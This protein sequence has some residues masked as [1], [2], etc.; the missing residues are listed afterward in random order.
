[1]A[2]SRVPALDPDAMSEHQRLVHDAILAGPR[3]VVRGPLQGWLQRPGLAEHAQTLGAY[4]RFGTS[5]PPRLT[6][7]AILVTAVF[8]QAGYEWRGHAPFALAA[9]LSPDI[10]E[11]L[12]IGTTPEFEHGDEQIVHQFAT[13]LLLGHAVTRPTWEHAQAALGLPGV[14]DLVGVLGYYALISMTIKAEDCGRCCVDVQYLRLNV[15]SRAAIRR[16]GENINLDGNLCP[17]M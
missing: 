11:A 10:V 8:W 13:E 2:S 16:R 3:G 12:R 9:G 15:C 4:C 14:V 7:L 6:E 17:I 5:L 1:M